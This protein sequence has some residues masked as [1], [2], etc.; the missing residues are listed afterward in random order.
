VGTGNG[1]DFDVLLNPVDG[2]SYVVQ[3]LPNAISAAAMAPRGSIWC[4]FPA[5]YMEKIV[6]D[7][8]VSEALVAECLDAPAAWTLAL[9]ARKKKKPVRDVTVFVLDRPRNAHLI[10]EIRRAGARIFLRQQGDLVGALLAA[11]PAMPVDLLMGIG[12]A[13]EGILAACA[14]KSL[15]AD[16][17]V[18]LKPQSRAERDDITAAGLEPGKIRR[19]ADIVA[20]DEIYFSAT[21][22]TESMLLKGVRFQGGKARTESIILR[23]ATGMR[24]R[25]ISDYRIPQQ[26]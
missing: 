3:S 15:G 12:G 22:I 2:A 8:E 16:M 14:V 18:R 24:R 6:A 9:V 17:L 4:P 13:Q 10:E 7:P 23:N 5:V 25:I 26:P 20:S 1:P 19:C 11:H 21:G